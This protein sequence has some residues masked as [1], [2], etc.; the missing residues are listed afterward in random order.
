MTKLVI[1]L[2]KLNVAVPHSYHQAV[3][4]INARASGWYSWVGKP[5]RSLFQTES[6]NLET[7]IGNV[8]RKKK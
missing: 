3:R 8:E 5:L 6:E 7:K 4:L 1:K 2:D